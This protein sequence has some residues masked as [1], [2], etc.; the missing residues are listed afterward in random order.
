MYDETF[1]QGVLDKWDI[2]LKEICADIDI[3]GSP[4][5]T[6]FRVV[7]KD[8]N[9]ELFIVEN[10]ADKQVFR[11]QVI[12]S[13]IRE[14]SINGLK[15]ALPYQKSKDLNEIEEYNQT[16][17]QVLRF[18][19]TDALQRPEY[20]FDEFRAKPITDFII[21]LKDAS[22]QC[23]YEDKSIFS[24]KDY[25]F[26]L[27]GQI[28]KHRPALDEKIK[29]LLNFVNT[30]FFKDYDMLPSTLCHG[31]YHCINILWKDNDVNKVIDWE[32]VGYKPQMY[33]LANMV[34]CLGIEDPQA[35][36]GPLVLK[37]MDILKKSK[38]FDDISWEKFL[39]MMISLR[40]AW[41]SEWLRKKD[42]EI[43]ELE[44]DYMYLLME[45]YDFINELWR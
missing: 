39:Y 34:G 11:K 24:L 30:N 20:I 6:E 17:W 18:I 29:P 5:R 4:E 31:D 36:K 21:D 26:E 33:D 15:Q 7:I 27:V 13:T 16:N 44:L 28:H 8:S 45:N 14:L 9:N 3:S 32:F 37:I 35:L 2:K 25:S 41:V 23:K 19:K 22:S 40:F 43:L 38:V 1:L 12:A 42:E 10:I